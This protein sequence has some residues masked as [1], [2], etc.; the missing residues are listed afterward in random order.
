M[1]RKVITGVG[2]VVVIIVGWLIFNHYHYT[3][4]GLPD[5]EIARLAEK[6]LRKQAPSLLQDNNPEFKKEMQNVE[7]L[8]IKE[9]EGKTYIIFKMDFSMVGPEGDKYDYL[10]YNAGTYMLG[11]RLVGKAWRGIF[12]SNGMEFETSFMGV[13][14]VDCGHHPGEG[15]FYGFCKDPSVDQAILEI[16]DQ[17]PVKIKAEE[18]LIFGQIPSGIVEINP[19]F[20]SSQG[21]EMEAVYSLRVAIVSEDPKTFEK[22]TNSPLNWWG[23]TAQ[24]LNYLPG[25]AVDAIW[26]CADQQE[27][28]LQTEELIKS[29][30]VL[31]EEGIPVVF[32]DIKDAEQVANIFKMKQVAGGTAAP[33]TIEG[34]YLGYQGKQLQVGLIT[35]D[36]ESDVSPLLGKSLELR[37]Q[38]EITPAEKI[39]KDVG[40]PAM[41]EIETGAAVKGVS[42]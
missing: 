7:I 27:Q 10:Q 40:K 19:R 36:D 39:A 8:A 18:R 11:Y 12:L 32:T 41:K 29:L 23:M 14:P 28:V 20:Y 3:P 13:A 15:I 33:E 9:L 31:A 26:I 38:V 42:Q 25:D 1:G 5:K 24:D 21:E 37:Y 22:Y 35:L 4:P 2:V 34:V 30:R 6:E 16:P 17:S